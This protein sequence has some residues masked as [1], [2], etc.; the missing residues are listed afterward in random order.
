MPEQVEAASTLT[1]LLCLQMRVS[2][3]MPTAEVKSQSEIGS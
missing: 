1:P 2:S 3:N